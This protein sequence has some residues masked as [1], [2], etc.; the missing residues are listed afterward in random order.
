MKSYPSKS[1]DSSEDEDV[2][3][4]PD[5][6]YENRYC[7]QNEFSI[8]DC[9]ENTKNKGNTKSLNSEFNGSKFQ[10]SKISDMCETTYKCKT[11]VINSN[12]IA[13][14]SMYNQN[15]FVFKSRGGWY[16]STICREAIENLQSLEL[17]ATNK[18][19]GFHIIERFGQRVRYC[20]CAFKQKVYMIGG[21][22]QYKE[23]ELMSCFCYDTECE[24]WCQIGDLNER[25][26]DTACTVYEGKIVVSGGF[27]NLA[28]VEAYD[29]YRKKWTY[30]PDMIDGRY[31]HASVSMGN[32]LFVIGGF[33]KSACEVFDSF[34]RKFSSL[35]IC[36]ELINDM[37]SFQAVCINRHIVIFGRK[38]INESKTKLFAYNVE[39]SQLKAIECGTLQNRISVGFTRYRC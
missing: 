14:I 37:D 16:E 10:W 38:G 6:L 22:S 34:S 5:V 39:T 33:G 9:G 31:D 28:T 35:T 25:R 11:A 29:Y 8:F 3:I 1:L 27:S 4:V 36:S 21:Y 20:F 17:F 2:F 32:K 15:N 18:K 24:E 23:E 19:V 26:Y 30:L 12:N 7:N 13:L